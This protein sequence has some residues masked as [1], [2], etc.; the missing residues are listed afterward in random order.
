MTSEVLVTIFELVCIMLLGF[1]GG[2]YFSWRA[3]ILCLVCSPIMIIG[4]YMMS[5][6]QFGNKGGRF[7]GAEAGVD[8]YA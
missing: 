1:C 7:K 2:L 5:T 8:S 4:M 3:A 6:M